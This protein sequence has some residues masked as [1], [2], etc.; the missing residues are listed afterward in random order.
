MNK[1]LH[2]AISFGVPFIIFFAVLILFTRMS[3]S[4]VAASLAV[5]ILS[6]LFIYSFIKMPIKCDQANC[7][8]LA[9][10]EVSPEVANSFLRHIMVR[11]HRCNKCGHLIEMPK[12]TRR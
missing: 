4:L 9:S 3:L 11:G 6:A 7:N 12:G 8:G 2:R 10:I 1:F 5:G